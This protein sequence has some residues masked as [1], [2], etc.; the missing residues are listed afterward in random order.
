[1]KE[2]PGERVNMTDSSQQ[3]ELLEK[4]GKLR[5]IRY[6][7]SSAIEFRETVSSTSRIIGQAQT[8]ED[9]L[10]LLKLTK[11]E[12]VPLPAS[13]SAFVTCFD[14]PNSLLGERNNG[15]CYKPD[16]SRF[17]LSCNDFDFEASDSQACCNYRAGNLFDLN[18]AIRDF[19]RRLRAIATEENRLR[20]RNS[21]SLNVQPAPS[22]DQKHEVSF[23]LE[24]LTPDE[25][26]KLTPERSDPSPVAPEA[27]LG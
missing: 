13:A 4:Y 24:G 3:G 18:L 25:A 9:A 5:R 20:L 23:V 7:V 11:F 19:D 10:D 17:R 22:P 6:L 27:V 8:P 14:V 16:L 2:T 26:A 21:I 12:V 1:V 15:H